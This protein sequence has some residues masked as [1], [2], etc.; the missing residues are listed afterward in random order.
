MSRRR[1]YEIVDQ[2]E[3]ALAEYTGAPYVV[4][5]DTCT[6]AIYLAL[7][8]KNQL[9]VQR[10]MAFAYGSKPTVALPR[11]TYVG[12]VQAA[13]NAGYDIVWTNEKWS[14]SYWLADNI[15][16]SAK[17]F[18]RGMY[19]AGTFTCVSFGSSKRLN[20]GRGGAILTDSKE[21]VDWIRPRSMDGRTPGEDYKTPSF[22]QPGWRMNMTP[23]IAARGLDLLTYIDDEDQC[24]WTEY[25]DLSRATWS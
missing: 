13:R 4:A 5:T 18:E 10:G 12:V 1:A 19:E 2:F 8:M 14:G 15:V 16:D 25:P 7:L 17:R 23:E 22:A 11:H 3:E 24:D 20:I 21:A 6:S 9:L